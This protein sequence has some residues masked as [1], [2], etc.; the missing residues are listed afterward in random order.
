MEFFLDIFLDIFLGILFGVSRRVE[1]QS[2][3]ET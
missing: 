2:R 1:V 3:R